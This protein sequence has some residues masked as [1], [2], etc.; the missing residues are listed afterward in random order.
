MNSLYIA[1]CSVIIF[2]IFNFI[3]SKFIKKNNKVIK[4]YCREGFMVFISVYL[5]I[6]ILTKLNDSEVLGLSKSSTPAFVGNPE[7]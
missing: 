2:L 1:I 6:I 5:G 4:E 7:F 3:D